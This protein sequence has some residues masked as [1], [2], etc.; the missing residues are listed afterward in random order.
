MSR[1]KREFSVAMLTREWPPKIY[2]GAGVHVRNLVEAIG[3]VPGIS[4]EVHCF[5]ETRRDARAHQIVGKLAGINPALQAL[6]IDVDMASA[7]GDCSLV[8]SHTWYTN[9]AGY[10]AQRAHQIPHVITAHS[11]EPLR[12]WKAEQLGGGYQISSWIE[13]IAYESADAIISVSDGM[14]RDILSAYP[15]VD[16]AK[17]HTIHNGIDVQSFSPRTDES[18]LRRFGIEEPFALFVGRITRQKGIAYLLR[19]W[20][21]VNPEFGLVLA[22]SN[23]D[24]P[25]IGAEVAALVEELQRT[26]DNIHWITDTL[27]HDDLVSLLSAARTFVCPSIYEPLGIVNLEAMACETA[28]VASAVGGIP[29]VVVD[30]QTGILVKFEESHFVENLAIA[31]NTVMSDEALADRLGKAGRERAAVLFGWDKVAQRTA[32][33]YRSLI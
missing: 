27:P 2:G 20:R 16:P 18:I 15:N 11:L 4:T 9:F 6:L 28:V 33:L 12:P 8:H 26:R 13:R 29:E 17:V 24:E 21:D 19:A 7:I 30:G 32:D 31:I 3:Q 22:A 14:K 5:G 25:A 23:P 10:F 1:E